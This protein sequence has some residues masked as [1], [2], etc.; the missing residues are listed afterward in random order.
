MSDVQPE[1]LK[2]LVRENIRARRLNLGL[3]Q[4]AICDR[5]NAKRRRKDPQMH[6]PYLSDVENGVRSPS[7]EIIAEL[8]EALET[9]PEWLVSE[10]EKIP[11]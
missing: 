9:T 11:A 5:V 8:A 7:L 3:S 1:Q 4:G 10:P 6:V 2:R